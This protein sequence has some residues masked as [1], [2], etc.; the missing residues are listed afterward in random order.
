MRIFRHPKYKAMPIFQNISNVLKIDHI[1]L[2]IQ[3]LI[4]KHSN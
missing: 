2:D 1:K 3:I 4:L